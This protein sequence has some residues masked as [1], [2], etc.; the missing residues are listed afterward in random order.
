MTGQPARTDPAAAMRLVGLSLILVPVLARAMSLLSML[1]GWDLDPLI[2]PMP[3]T[4]IGPAESITIDC[5]A[6]LGAAIMAAFAR[7]VPGSSPHLD[8]LVMALLALGAV[9]VLLHMRAWPWLPDGGGLGDRRIGAAWLAALL[10]ATA[11]WLCRHDASLRRIAAGV[12]LGFVAMLAAKAA[13]QILVEHPATVAQYRADPAR[14]LAGQGLRPDSPMARAF[15]RRLLQP[16]ATGWF[17]LANVFATVMAAAVVAVFSLLAIAWM[18]RAPVPRTS[19]IVILLA[20]ACAVFGLIYA[21]AKGG[22][23]AAAVGFSGV[24]LALILTRTRLA[25]SRRVLLGRFVGVAAVVAPIALIV[26]RGLS[27]ERG[28]GGE[29]SLLFRWFYMQGSLR[30]FADHPWGVG[31]DGFQQAYLLAKPP[32]SPEEVSSPHGILFDWLADLGVAGGAWVVLL[33]IAAAA[34]GRVLI[35]SAAQPAIAQPSD[36]SPGGSAAAHHLEMRLAL[37]IPGLATLLAAWLERGA[38]TPDGAVVRL[39]GLIGWCVIAVAVLNVTRNAPTWPVGFAA[40][41][42]AL[43]AHIQIDVAASWAQSVGI[44]ALWIALAASGCPSPAPADSDV[45]RGRNAAK[46]VVLLLALLAI[47]GS[48]PLSAWNWQRGLLDAKD[49]LEPAARLNQ[50]F[51]ALAAGAPSESPSALAEAVAAELRRRL[52]QQSVAT[53]TTGQELGIAMASLEAID[54][55]I[56]SRKLLE[57]AEIEPSVWQ[58]RREASRILL[59][60]SSA[61]AAAGNTAGSQG[62]LERAAAAMRLPDPHEPVGGSGG[63]APEWRWLGIVHLQQADAASEPDARAEALRKAAAAFERAV[64]L[65]PYNLEIALR[66]MRTYSSVAEPPEAGQA[67]QAWA[68]KVLELAP[69][70]RL[71]PQARGLTESERSEAEAVLRRP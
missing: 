5:I 43:L 64:A 28:W 22:A 66:L 30:I 18:K 24:I 70:M 51:A 46:F 32:Q 56:A 61:A 68:R 20:G 60:A 16:E 65:D 47:L 2:V 17:G 34:V 14:F 12:L 11:L 39:A 59:R 63:S 13:L 41:A 62:L 57:A 6:C 55:D 71:D 49:S 67:A 45:R 52:P 53:P 3:F 69:L 9:G 38:V 40:G 44:V 21:G 25:D 33:L 54:L 23:L 58:A 7:R 37:L 35:A 15:E 27:G 29:L 1:P 48:R 8:R 36:P 26:L 42:A 4:G 10:G 31:P 19:I 50:R